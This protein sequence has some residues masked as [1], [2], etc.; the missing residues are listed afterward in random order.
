MF[1]LKKDKGMVDVACRKFVKENYKKWEHL[2]K[3]TEDRTKL[4]VKGLK[5]IYVL[6]DN[7]KQTYY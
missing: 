1:I 4:K 5:N 6:M 2:K 3:E 7:N